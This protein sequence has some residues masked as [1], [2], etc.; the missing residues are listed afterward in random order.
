MVDLGSIVRIFC[1]CSSF[2]G[3]YGAY[4]FKEYSVKVF[5]LFLVYFGLMSPDSDCVVSVHS[6]FV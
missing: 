6:I 4:F 1:F 5:L 2:I 3:Y